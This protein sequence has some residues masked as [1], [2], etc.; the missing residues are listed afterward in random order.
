M[1]II[2]SKEISF[3]LSEKTNFRRAT[4][5]QGNE[6]VIEKQKQFNVRWMCDFDMR[7]YPLDNQTRL[8]T[9]RSQPNYIEVLLL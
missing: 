7:R 8:I 6:N 9:M 2:P 4:L 1:T 5:F 3:E